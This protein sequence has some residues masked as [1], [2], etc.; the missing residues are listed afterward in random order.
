MSVVL[1]DV[2]E[3]GE[4]TRRHIPKP[5]KEKA[6][7]HRNARVS[8]KPGKSRA[9]LTIIHPNA[10]GIGAAFRGSTSAIRVADAAFQPPKPHTDAT[11]RPA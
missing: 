6:L 5:M 7:A 9:A 1:G 2:I 8:L 4:S 11:A 3:I 10:A